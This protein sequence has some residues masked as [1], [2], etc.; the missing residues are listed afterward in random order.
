MISEDKE[1]IFTI[2]RSDG[3]KLIL[4]FENGIIYG[5]WEL[6]YPD[7][8]KITGKLFDEKMGFSPTFERVDELVKNFPKPK[9]IT[10]EDFGIDE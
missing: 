6:T 9:E 1:D 7:G 5:S 2:E 10:S 8:V 4:N 3:G